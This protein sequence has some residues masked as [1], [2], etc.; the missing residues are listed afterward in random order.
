MKLKLNFEKTSFLLIN[1]KV[2]IC[3]LYQFIMLTHFR[4]LKNSSV[5]KTLILNFKQKSLKPLSFLIYPNFNVFI[6]STAKIEFEIGATLKL[7]F[8]WP[9]SIYKKSMLKIMDNAKFKFSN[10]LDIHTGAYISVDKNASL[11]INSGYINNDVRIYCFNSIKIGDKVAIAEDVIIR[12]SDNHPI[13]GD[14]QNVSQPIVIGNKVWIG[15]RA[16][17]LKGVTIGDGA[18]IAAGAVV[19]KD[20]PSGALVGGIPAKLLKKDV[21]WL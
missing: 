9:K 10:D 8:T 15:M 2:D 3:Y 16:T 14:Y 6:H 11:E 17:I 18:I 1:T 4:K 5:L 12:D 21:I 13:N 20:V 19:N 7:G